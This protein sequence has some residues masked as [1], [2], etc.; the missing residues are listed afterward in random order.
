AV[1]ICIKN[2]EF[3]KASK[4]LKKH[5]SKDPTTQKLRNDLLNIIREKNLAH[6]VIQNFSYETFQQKMLRFLESHLDDAEPYLL[7]IGFVSELVCILSIFLVK[8][9][10]N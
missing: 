10:E 5:M 2:K 6:P 8:E 1:I 3:E 9:A 7:T 4:I